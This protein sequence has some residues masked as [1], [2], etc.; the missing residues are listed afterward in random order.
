MAEDQQ[1][2]GQEAPTNDTPPKTPE[3]GSSDSWLAQ[4][5]D[6]AK[7]YIK[8]LRDENAQRRVKER[9]ARQALDAQETARRKQ[10]EADL[11][12]QQK[13]QELAE[14][15]E[16]EANDFKAQLEA[17]RVNNLRARIALEM[18]LPPALAARLQGAT[19]DEIRND[20]QQLA[21]LIQQPQQEQ[22]T[23]RSQTTSAVPDGS[24]TRETD[25]QKRANLGLKRNFTPPSIFDDVTIIERD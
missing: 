7:T 17:E 13:W 22:Q 15:R 11:A 24:P 25:D 23:A 14:R 12:A 6:E 2:N 19:E 10:E 20:A 1:N 16:K 21:A 4:L 18:R 9:E 3:T 8:E 5:P